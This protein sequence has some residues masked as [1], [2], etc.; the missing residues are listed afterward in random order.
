VAASEGRLKKIVGM[1]ATKVEAAELLRL[2]P[3]RLRRSLN[4][5]IANVLRRAARFT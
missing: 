3:R 5:S 2:P 1:L 4:V